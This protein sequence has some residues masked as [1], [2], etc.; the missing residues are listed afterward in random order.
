MQ[1][2]IADIESLRKRML[3]EV[4]GREK[5]SV[6]ALA[7]LIE[8]H[9]SDMIRMLD[10]IRTSTG[11]QRRRMADMLTSLAGDFGFSRELN[12]KP[13]P[14]PR[15]AQPLRASVPLPNRPAYVPP[16]PGPQ[17]GPMPQPHRQMT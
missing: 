12:E 6:Q 5:E 17:V 13:E 3:A 14:L 15:I 4:Q 1:D 8:T 10:R 11:E 2:F 9:N 7:Q 16:Y